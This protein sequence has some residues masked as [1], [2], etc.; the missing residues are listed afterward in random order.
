MCTGRRC[1]SLSTASATYFPDINECD[2]DI[3]MMR[4]TGFELTNR[5]GIKKRQHKMLDYDALRAKVKK[6]TEKP[7]KDPG[8]LP[9]TEKETEMVGIQQSFNNSCTNTTDSRDSLDGNRDDEA[10][11]AVPSPPKALQRPE[12]ERLKSQQAQMPPRH[13]SLPMNR[14]SSMMSQAS[15]ASVDRERQ[16]PSLCGY[17]EAHQLRYKRT[18]LPPIL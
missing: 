1:S 3:A 7:D 4:E 9:R 11:L 2:V 16:A 8:K 5:P 17:S 6:L 15:G 10:D 13:S 18:Q 14:S 12:I